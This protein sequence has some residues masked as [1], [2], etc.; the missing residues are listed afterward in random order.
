MAEFM[1]AIDHITYYAVR[2]EDEIT[3]INLALGGQ[4]QE[5][6]SETRDAYITDYQSS[7][8]NPLHLSPIDRDPAF[9]GARSPSSPAHGQ[10]SPPMIAS[11]IER[12]SV[13]ARRTA[14]CPT[15][16]VTDETRTGG[17]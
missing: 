4:G 9:P 16:S 17:A 12:R 10:C 15:T 3:A 2:A 8:A 7:D 11:P 14:T 13:G 6:A 5:I 1:V